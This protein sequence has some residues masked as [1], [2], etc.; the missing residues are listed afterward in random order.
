MSIETFGII[1]VSL[2]L[3]TLA[4]IWIGWPGAI[5]FWLAASCGFIIWICE[6]NEYE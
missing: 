3:G 6:R 1:F 5:W 4:Q 2:L